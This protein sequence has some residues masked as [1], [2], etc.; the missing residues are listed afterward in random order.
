MGA[1]FDLFQ[2][3]REPP[4]EGTGTF[5]LADIDALLA[6]MF[7]SEQAQPDYIHVSAVS[8]TCFPS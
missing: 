5:S 6:Q 8:L 3:M 4:T 7:A 2:A 1:Q